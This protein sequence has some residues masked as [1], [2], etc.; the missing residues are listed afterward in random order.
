MIVRLVTE[1]K[2]RI[3]GNPPKKYRRSANLALKL[4]KKSPQDCNKR[5]AAEETEEL[6]QY[7]ES[8][9]DMLWHH[10]HFSGIWL[11]QNTLWQLTIKTY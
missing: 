9:T 2:K 5:E 6:K 8:I 4:F 3:S 7:I 10:V 11:K 1:K